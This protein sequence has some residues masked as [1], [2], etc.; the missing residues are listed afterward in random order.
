MTA[1][2]PINTSLICLCGA[3]TCPAGRRP[4]EAVWAHTHY[5]SEPVASCALEDAGHTRRLLL[6]A[7]AGQA[8]RRRGCASMNARSGGALQLR[9][10]LELWRVFDDAKRR[11]V[12]LRTSEAGGVTG[13]H[14]L[15][16][17]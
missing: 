4:N 3:G 5:V 15:T 12:G 13:P 14:P 1:P 17:H 16:H 2:H 8:A 9:G 11:D 6:S 7:C 10:R